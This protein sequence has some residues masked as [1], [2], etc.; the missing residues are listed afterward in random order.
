MMHHDIEAHATG[1]VVQSEGS[2]LYCALEVAA[3]VGLTEAQSDKSQI[4]LE[5]L[6]IRTHP[7]LVELAAKAEIVHPLALEEGCDLGHVIHYC[8]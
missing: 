4:Y 1:V 6:R 3:Q 8:L 2:L 7:A 5:W